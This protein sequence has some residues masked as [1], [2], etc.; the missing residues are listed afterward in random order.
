MLAGPP[1][2]HTQTNRKRRAGVHTD[3]SAHSSAHPAEVLAWGR[4]AVCID[5]SAA[6]PSTSDHR[7]RVQ[8]V[9]EATSPIT[10]G[11]PRGTGVAAAHRESGGSVLTDE[12]TERSADRRWP[13]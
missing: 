3:G 7:A 10:R 12:R 5:P 1:L 6:T 2:E 4:T 9:S 13:S 11:R 8:A